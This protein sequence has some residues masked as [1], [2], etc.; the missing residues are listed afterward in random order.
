M[1]LNGGVRFTEKGLKAS[2]RAMHVQSELVSMTNEN[3]SGFDKVGYQRKDPVVS[4]F[5]EIL[6]VHGL[7]QTVDDQVGR[8]SLT[9]NPLDF[10]LAEKGYF[11]IQTPDGVQLTRDGRFRL[12]KEG[13]LLTLEDN[14]V[15]ST[16][17]VPIV[18]PFIPDSI[19][20]IKVNRKGDISVFN[21]K[22]NKMESLGRLGV[23]DSNGYVVMS[24]EV[25]QGYNE[26]SKS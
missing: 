24:P 20:D 15:L 7:S 3:I 26:F 14:K 5:T 6:G 11:Q 12:D 4:S 2:L 22:T 8:I 9:E 23:V 16:A 18:L 17:G 19:K 1:Q 13:N 10:A 25:M 21:S